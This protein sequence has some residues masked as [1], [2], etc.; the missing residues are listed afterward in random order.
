MLLGLK[1]GDSGAYVEL[2][3]LALVRAVES[4]LLIDGIFGENTE[5]ALLEFQR[6]NVLEING[7]VDLKTQNALEDYLKG[8]KVVYISGDDTFYRLARRYETTVAA[9][10]RANPELNPRNLV[11]GTSVY[12]PFAYPLV[13]TKVHY[14]YYYLSLLCDGFRVRFPFVTVQTI[15]QTVLGKNIYCIK[16]GRGSKRIMY[17]AAHHANEWITTPLVLKY[18]ESYAEAVLAGNSVYDIDAR[19]LY[20]DTELY[21]VPMVDADGV[22]LV[23]GVLEGAPYEKAEEIADGFPDI[24]FPSGW[25]ANASG[26]D[27][28]LNYPAQWERAKEIKYALG[29]NRPAPRD[30]VGTAP[31][32][33]PESIAMARLTLEND[34][35]LT[36]SYH[37][38][39]NVIYWKF[40]DYEP[41]RSL[42][43]GQ[44]F[45]AASGYPL[46]LTPSA[47]GA[48]GYKD[49]FIQEYNRP[50]YTVEVGLG[51]SPVPLSQ[52]DEIYKNN[53]GIMTLGMQML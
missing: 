41:P 18:M 10:R 31:L 50:G 40:D 39:G 20:F 4:E 30:Y 32:T 12:V 28:N 16:L 5:T 51:Q 33:A 8:Y 2:V 17:N 1:N 53:I 11:D 27:L 42:E 21:V 38:Q 24:P 3:Q 14:T 7:Y 6:Q 52:F 34:F 35:L 45:S 46:E 36:I 22:D 37:T 13:S 43:I 48:A 49:W 15:G 29:F 19:T 44:A 23:N 9:I 26:V 25:K 47:S